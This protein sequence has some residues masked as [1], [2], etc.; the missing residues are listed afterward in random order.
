VICRLGCLLDRFSGI[1]FLAFGDGK[2]S[3]MLYHVP[4]HIILGSQ[5]R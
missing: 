3:V 4:V 1:A 5:E 2:S